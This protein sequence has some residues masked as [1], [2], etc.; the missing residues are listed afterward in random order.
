MSIG[1]IVVD[2]YSYKAFGGELASGNGTANP[3]RYIGLYGYYVDKTTRLYV[4]ARHLDVTDGR[5]MSKDPIG[6]EGGDTNLFRYVR[7]GPVTLLDPDGLDCNPKCCCCVDSLALTGIKPINS[8]T[9]FGHSFNATA[10]M[11]HHN[12][13]AG[14]VS[15]DCKLEWFEKSNMPETSYSPPVPQAGRYVDILPLHP[16]LFQWP[17]RT[18]PCPGRETFPEP[19]SPILAIK[20]GRTDRRTLCFRIV[21]T[22]APKCHC[23]QQ[24]LEVWAKQLLSISMGKIVVQTFF[25]PYNPAGYCK[26]P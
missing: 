25:Y 10:T 4:R 8:A 1:G 3:H 17:S 23:I 14:E 5:W 11:Y 16:E 26:P 2:S 12:T 13:G 24:S 22:S 15:G 18:P 9:R 21:V 19:D 7:N 6:F 20:A